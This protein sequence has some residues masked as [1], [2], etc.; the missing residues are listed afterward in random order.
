MGVERDAV[1][2]VVTLPPGLTVALMFNE[3]WN[4]GAGPVVT[5]S[6][7]DPPAGTGPGCVHD[8]NVFSGP[9][10]HP[11]PVADGERT[12]IAIDT[13]TGPGAAAAPRLLTVAV[14][15]AT[16]PA[17]YEAGPVRATVRS[18]CS[19]VTGVEMSFESLLALASIGPL[20][21]MLADTDAV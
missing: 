13:V 7:S 18:Y 17:L 10:V 12:G 19:A 1:L 15:D 21:K 6:G 16:P 9:H 4:V 11:E 3:D 20:R 14:S 5:M 8:S 2:L